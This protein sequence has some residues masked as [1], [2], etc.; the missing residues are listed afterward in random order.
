MAL[1][2]SPMLQEPLKKTIDQVVLTF[3][4]PLNIRYNAERELPARPIKISGAEICD[5]T[6]SD[7][8]LFRARIQ[9]VE[10]SRGFFIKKSELGV[11]LGTGEPGVKL[12]YYRIREIDVL[13]TKRMKG[14]REQTG[15]YF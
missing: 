5:F 15:E 9:E 3:D 7:Y 4:D 11:K 8:V 12:E 10:S 13:L 14:I 6:N 2:L 1:P